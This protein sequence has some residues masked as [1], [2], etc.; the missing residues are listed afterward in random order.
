MPPGSHFLSSLWDPLGPE[1]R[2]HNGGVRQG[3]CQVR[4]LLHHHQLVP[5]GQDAEDERQGVGGE[6]R[7]ARPLQ[8]GEWVKSCHSH[9]PSNNTAVT[10]FGPNLAVSNKK[11]VP[12]ANIRAS[13]IHTAGCLIR[14][15]NEMLMATN[16]NQEWLK[17]VLIQCFNHNVKLG[18]WN[19]FDINLSRFWW[20]I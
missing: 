19:L 3:R 1:V 17:V 13:L 10:A 16:I 4:R 14:C 11:G 5:A 8:I 18:D 2:T 7:A 9:C 15:W 6:E 12:W 20:D